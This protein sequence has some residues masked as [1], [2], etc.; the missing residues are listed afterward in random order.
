MKR[1]KQ[2]NQKVVRRANRTRAKLFGT[3]K[4]PRVSAFRSNKALYVQVIDDEKGV[5]IAAGSTKNLSTGKD[6]ERAKALGKVLAEKVKEK[7]VTSAIFDRGRYK[8]HGKIK[9][10]ADGLREGGLKI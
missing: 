10:L 8:Y 3:A 4:R 2:Q 1:A 9:A 6:V 7:K 5:T